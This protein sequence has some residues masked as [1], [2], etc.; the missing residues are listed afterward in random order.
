MEYFKLSI[1]PTITAFQQTNSSQSGL[2]VVDES[3]QSQQINLF[4]DHA[5]E[6]ITEAKVH[7]LIHSRCKFYRFCYL[8]L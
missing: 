5:I 1:V 8:F 4:F 2:V 7:T 6:C 3:T